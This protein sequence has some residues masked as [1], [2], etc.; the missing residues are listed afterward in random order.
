MIARDQSRF[1]TKK[2]PGVLAPW[3]FV[4]AR[5]KSRHSRNSRPLRISATRPREIAAE[6]A[7]AFGYGISDEM[8]GFAAM[9]R[10]RVAGRR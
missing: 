2:T 8:S 3:V 7:D 10:E 4:R 1:K 6:Y 9:W 5:T